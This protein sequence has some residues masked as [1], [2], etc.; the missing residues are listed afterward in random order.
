MSPASSN[1]LP[2]LAESI[3]A[4]ERAAGHAPCPR[5]V[6]DAETW[7]GLGRELAGGRLS[8]LG[9][10]G[11]ASAVHM[12]LLRPEPAEIAVV[13]LATT[14]RFPSIAAAHPPALRLERAVADLCG[15]VAEGAPD[16]RPWLDHGTW[17]A[18]HPLAARPE[19]PIAAERYRFLPVEGESL[20]QIPVGPVHAGI[21]EPGHFRFTPPA[22][23]PW[24]G[25]RSAWATCTR[26]SRSSWPAPRSSARHGSPAAFRATAPSPTRSPSPAPSRPPS[27]SR[28]PPRAHWLRALM[29]ELERLAN[30]LGDIGAICNDASFSILHTQC[31]MLREAVLRTADTC[32]GHRLMMDRII[33]GGVTADLEP[34]GA[35][36]LT[37]LMAEIRRRFPAIVRIYDS[38]ASLQNRTVGTG[39]L[40]PALARTYAAGGYVGRA[41]GRRFDAR[42]FPSYPPYDALE[43]AVPVLEAGDVNAR[44]WI[45]IREVEESLKLIEAMLA[46]LP[47]GAVALTLLPGGRDRGEG[48]AL[49]EGF[50]GDILVVAA[51]RGGADRALPPA[52]PVMVPLAAPRGGDRR[53][54]RRRL[55]ALQQILQLLLFGARPLRRP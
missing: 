51:D 47:G 15:L 29:A 12:A 4:L 21:I 50:R 32:F 36:A 22:A 19:T 18:R 5:L 46:Q 39:H 44:V 54:H 37:L 16:P 14:G 8:L 20:H 45:R 42:R 26:G 7:Q 2:A 25:S 27:A 28:P 10:W 6:V 43:P 33:P 48:L 38:T 31:G 40:S 13:S 23:R 24:S 52:R 30:H 17:T 1:S 3:A 11:E 35:V 41:S 55:P 34:T 53:Q 9:L 49:V